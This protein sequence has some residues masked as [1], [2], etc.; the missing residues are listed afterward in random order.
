MRILNTDLPG[1]LVLEPD[2]FHD[3]RGYFL[4]TFHQRKYREAGIPHSFVQDNQ[5]RSTRGALRG[6]HAQRV[7]LDLRANLGATFVVV[8]HELD[9]IFAIGNNSVFLDIDSR[10]QIALG[11]PK[12][13]RDECDDPTVRSFLTRG[14]EGGDQNR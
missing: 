14:R 12:R 9:S 3:P 7:I 10:T 1:V 2:V 11:D 8:T 5:S 6:M 13:L 4:E